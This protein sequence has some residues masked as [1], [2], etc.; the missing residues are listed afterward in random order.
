VILNRAKVLASRPDAGAE[1]CQGPMT[2]SIHPRSMLQSSGTKRER[3]W[4]ETALRAIKTLVSGE[5]P[6]SLTAEWRGVGGLGGATRLRP[7][8][9]AC[10]R[11]PR[12]GIILWTARKDSSLACESAPDAKR[13]AAKDRAANIRPLWRTAKALLMPSTNSRAVVSEM[14]IAYD[15]VRKPGEAGHVCDPPTGPKMKEPDR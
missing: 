7:I 10:S 1:L 2:S 14:S 13:A 12:A 4:R 11:S 3:K 5:R 6:G 9:E 15:I 8:R